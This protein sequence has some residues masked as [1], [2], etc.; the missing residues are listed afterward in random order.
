MCCGAIHD[1]R[2]PALTAEELM[3]S[4]YT[5]FVVGDADWLRASWHPST[6]PRRVHVSADDEWLGLTV[7]AAD[8]G[9]FDDEGAVHYVAEVRRDAAVTR[10][11]ER[12]RFVR[13][14][15]SWVYLDGAIA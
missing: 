9:P 3:R 13:H 11:E 8:G 2:R 1:G 6:R 7:L 15:G 4:R 12:S 10:L 5:A 14:D